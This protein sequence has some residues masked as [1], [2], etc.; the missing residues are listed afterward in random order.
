M[1]PQKR[2]F[3][4]TETDTRFAKLD[5]MVVETSYI[6]KSVELKNLTFLTP[7]LLLPLPEVSTDIQRTPEIFVKHIFALYLKRNNFI[8]SG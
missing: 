4:V 7:I 2:Q 8:S 3:L 5:I 6:V 1:L